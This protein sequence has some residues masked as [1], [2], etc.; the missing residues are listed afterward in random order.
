M[1]FYEFL[2][3]ADAEELALAVGGFPDAVGMKH[4]NIARLQRDSPLVV[5]HVFVDSQRKARQFDFAAPVVLV[6]KW[7]RLSGIRNTQFLAA[8]LP[9][10]EARSH[11]P[12]LDAPFA[13]QLI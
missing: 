3:P 9:C 8:L 6:K 11:E 13:N 10:R 2:K 1:L 5:G 12:P 4:E 7:L